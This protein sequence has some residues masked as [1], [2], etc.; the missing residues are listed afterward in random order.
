M[1]VTVATP[2]EFSQVATIKIAAENIKKEY[3]DIIKLMCRTKKIP[4]FRAGKIPSDVVIK[5]YG[6]DAFNQ[7][8]NH[9]I[10]EA[11]RQYLKENKPKIATTP[12][13]TI[14]NNPNMQEDG[15]EFDVSYDIFPDCNLKEL[16]EIEVEKLTCDLTD[17]DVDEVIL[18]VRKSQGYFV[19]VEGEEDAT[20]KAEDRIVVDYTGT[21]DGKEFPNNSDKGVCLNIYSEPEGNFTSFFLDHKVGDK[22]EFDY[23][24]PKGVGSELEE[25]V[26]HFNAE[27]HELYRRT[28]PEVNKDFFKRLE[29]DPEKT[30]IESFKAEIVKNLERE[31]DTM[32]SQLN[33]KK[34]FDV[35]KSSNEIK[36]PESAV[37]EACQRK[38]E[39]YMQNGNSRANLVEKDPVELFGNEI[40]NSIIDD[41]IASS[42]FEK[43]DIKADDNEVLDYLK[44]MSTTYQEPNRVFNRLKKTD[45]V[46]GNINYSLRVKKLVETVFAN[47][48]VTEKTMP[49]SEL[50]LMAISQSRGR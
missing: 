42:L 4:G 35:L 50:K 41:M 21:L 40:R 16:S 13:I 36:V 34:V 7:A 17:A 22:F 5:Y 6:S 11:Y 24:F 30:T 43:F 14:K 37:K 2:S 10:D 23:T 31:K 1:Q 19:K 39:S 38:M 18:Q 28:I 45:S 3:Q 9:L 33:Y 47:A 49:F 32:L 12:K 20:V 29:M 46:L 48:K 25:K 27:I 15:L 26:G 44:Q 8:V